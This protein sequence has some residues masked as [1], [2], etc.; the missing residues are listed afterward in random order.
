MPLGCE[1]IGNKKKYGVLES[2]SLLMRSACHMSRRDLTALPDSF[3]KYGWHCIGLCKNRDRDIYE[4][5]CMVQTIALGITML[6]LVR[7]MAY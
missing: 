7:A 2:L 1:K 6:W 5:A 3:F 4:L